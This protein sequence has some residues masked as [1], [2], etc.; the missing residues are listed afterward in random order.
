MNRNAIGICY[1]NG[2][3]LPLSEARVSVLD[4]GFIFGDAV[5]E[6]IPAPHGNLFAWDE[7][8]L[9]LK[10]S[11]AATLIPNP[12]DS[13]Q[14]RSCLERLIEENAASSSTI[15]LQISRGAAERNHAF[16]RDVRPTVFAMW[17]S[18][19]INK[20][21]IKVSAI[22]VQDNRWGRCDIKSTSLLANVLLRNQAITCGAYEALLIRDGKLT[23]GAASNVFVVRDGKVETPALSTQ[24][25]AGVTRGLLLGVLRDNGMKVAETDI[26]PAALEGAEE[27]WITSSSCDLMCVSTLDGEMVGDGLNYPVA[28]RALGLLHDY[29]STYPSL[30]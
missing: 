9:R 1:L 23:E 3:Y 26:T 12:M 24:L 7:H 4:R 29:K 15:Y 13:A 18:L 16:P 5:Y 25:L 27:V 10:R 19:E 14:W 6:V 11:L 17:R 30:P 28:E 21:I 8:Y 2:D 20:A 22:S